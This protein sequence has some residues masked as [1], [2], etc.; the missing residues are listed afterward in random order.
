M[1]DSLNPW[2]CLHLLVRGEHV[3][4]FS[5][6]QEVVDV[7]NKGLILDLGVAEKEDSVL[8]LTSCPAQ[9]ALQILPPFHLTI[10]LGNLHLH[11]ISW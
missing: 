3:G 7:L 2:A 8:A 6:V 10:A 11:M 4:H 1:Q 9:D 5:A